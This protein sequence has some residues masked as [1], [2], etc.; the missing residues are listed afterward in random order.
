MPKVELQ[1]DRKRYRPLETLLRGYAATDGNNLKEISQMLGYKDGRVAG[2]RF[3]KPE[4]LT[5]KELARLGRH[6]NI[7]IEQ[8]R[9]TAIVY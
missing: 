2:R 8:L 3:S 7:P 5:L 9:D 1:L 6:L 4:T